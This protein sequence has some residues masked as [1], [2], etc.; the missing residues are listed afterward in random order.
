[1]QLKTCYFIKL[2]YQKINIVLGYNIKNLSKKLSFYCSPNKTQSWSHVGLPGEAIQEQESH[3]HE[4]PV[5]AFNSCC[6]QK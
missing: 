4:G 6:W 5:I 1:M 2:K 3:N